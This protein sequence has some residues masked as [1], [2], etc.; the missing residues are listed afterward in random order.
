MLGLQRWARLTGHRNPNTGVSP[1]GEEIPVLT[2]AE[3]RIDVPRIHTTQGMTFASWAARVAPPVGGF[4]GNVTLF[5]AGRDQGDLGVIIVSPGAFDLTYFFVPGL[6]RYQFEVLG[7]SQ[8]TNGAKIVYF[9]E[10]VTSAPGMPWSSQTI[11]IPQCTFASPS[12][13]GR[14]R[15]QIMLPVPFI[16]GCAAG[17]LGLAQSDV[18]QVNGTLEPVFLLDEQ[19][20][21]SSLP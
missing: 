18:V 21:A 3:S 16:L 2:A 6:Y 8:A 13:S 7:V 17:T 20:S 10:S 19:G 14:L 9:F 11:T 1:P 15:G 4:A 12:A 5:Q